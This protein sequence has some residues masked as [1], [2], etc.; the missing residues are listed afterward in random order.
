ML[1]VDIK[2]RL[3][4]YELC[5]HLESD[6][7]VLGLFGVSGAGKSMTLKCIAGIEK[8]DSGVIRLN[9]RVLFDSDRHICVRPQ[10]RAVGYLFQEY[11]LFP[12][13]TVQ[14]NI[15]VGLHRLS[16]AERPAQAQRL[17]EEFRIAHLAHKRP[18]N[19]SG[20]ERQRTALAR[21]FASS[22]E[23]I[24]LDE[25]FSSLDTTLK[26]EL[27]PMM[28]EAI[29]AYGKGCL[30]VSHD[31]AELGAVCDYVATITGGVSSAAAET[32]AFME[33]VRRKYESLG[34]T[35]MIYR[36]KE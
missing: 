19:L 24:L 7:G 18:D 10:E 20:G 29:A 8:P 27:I 16:R 6:G 15:I 12:N 34:V 21:I 33:D 28:R 4:S 31:V 36:S 13:M 30:M 25:P 1:Y 5:V 26:C 17:M 2:K 22:P 23:L 9:D 32:D 3:S 14:G 11:A 35:P